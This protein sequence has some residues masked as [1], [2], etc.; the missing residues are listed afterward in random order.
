MFGISGIELMIILVVVFLI[1]GP[2]EMPKI[3]RTIG[4]ALKMFNEARQE[5]ED[6]IKTEIFNP[7]DAQMLSDPLGLK[8]MSKEFEDTFKQMADPDHKPV[9]KG[10]GMRVS[11]DDM[12]QAQKTSAQT[13]S[14][15][16]IGTTEADA[17]ENDSSE[18]TPITTS[19]DDAGDKESTSVESSATTK[20]QELLVPQVDRDDVA[21]IWGIPVAGG[22]KDASSDAAIPKTEEVLAEVIVESTE[23]S[24]GS[25]AV[26]TGATPEEAS[27]A[28]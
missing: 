7:E 15:T 21:S 11:T 1:F 26:A 10:A 28:C 5:V 9:P 19:P 14:K 16:S 23:D 4:Q 22:A 18:S 2:E 13:S 12:M 27:D 6:V 17:R 8:G 25:E 24:T 3:G 20:K